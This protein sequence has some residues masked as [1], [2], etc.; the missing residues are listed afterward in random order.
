MDVGRPDRQLPGLGSDDLD[1]LLE[2][3][4]Q[5]GVEFWVFFSGVLAAEREVELDEGARVVLDAALAAVDAVF[6]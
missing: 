5:D 4:P 6:R 1:V 2:T 3:L